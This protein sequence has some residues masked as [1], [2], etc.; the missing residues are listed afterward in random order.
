MGASLTSG[1]LVVDPSDVET[2]TS[3]RALL[4]GADI[5]YL[6]TAFLANFLCLGALDDCVLIAGLVQG[7]TCIRDEIARRGLSPGLDIGPEADDWSASSGR[8]RH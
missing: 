3:V 8:F 4:R 6:K 7:A 2:V 5:E 1:T